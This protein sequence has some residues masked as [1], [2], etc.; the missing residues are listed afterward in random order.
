MAALSAFQIPL[1][2]CFRLGDFCFVLAC[3]KACPF[4]QSYG[5][6]VAVR[7]SSRV[8]GRESPDAAALGA[9]LP[10]CQS[11]A[12]S[13]GGIQPAHGWAG[14]QGMQSFGPGFVRAGSPYGAVQPP[15]EA[16]SKGTDSESLGEGHCVAMYNLAIQP[17]FASREFSA[18]LAVAISVSPKTIGGLPCYTVNS[19]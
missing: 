7:P 3:R 16:G 9:R 5:S 13:F 12:A 8:S 10:E 15:V 11:R 1:K 4:P 19:R 2:I 18:G 6:R 14:F 17:F